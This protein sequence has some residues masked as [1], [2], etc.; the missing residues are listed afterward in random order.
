MLHLLTP[1]TYRIWIGT[2]EVCQHC[3]T[4]EAFIFNGSTD[5]RRLTGMCSYCGKKGMRHR[6]ATLIFD[7]Q[8]VR[9]YAEC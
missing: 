8:S 1:P 2:A 6:V 4:D 9:V 3:G 5:I 7:G